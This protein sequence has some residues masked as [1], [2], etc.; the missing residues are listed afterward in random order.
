M[1]EGDAKEAQRAECGEQHAPGEAPRSEEAQVATRGWPTD[2]SPTLRSQS[3]EGDE[4]R[5]TGDD[6]AE[7]PRTASVPGLDDAIH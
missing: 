1:Q 5:E 7:R 6:G 3:T 4:S 2:R